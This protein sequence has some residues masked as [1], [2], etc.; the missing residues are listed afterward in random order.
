VDGASAVG[1]IGKA[2][3]VG[4]TQA[5]KAL[6]GS[7]A[8]LPE[9]AVANGRV[10]HGTGT[11]RVNPNRTTARACDLRLMVVRGAWVYGGTDTTRAPRV[12]PIGW[13]GSDA[14]DPGNAPHP[15]AL[16]YQ[17]NNCLPTGLR[18]R[19]CRASGSSLLPCWRAPRS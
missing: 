9:G 14:S 12:G 3:L 8:T 17:E 15:P 4:C 6:P 1:I 2:S 5:L 7:G 11:T 10:Q 18:G 19:Q 13:L 16:T